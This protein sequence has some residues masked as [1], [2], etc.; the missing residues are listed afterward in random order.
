MKNTSILLRG[1]ALLALSGPALAQGGMIPL[2]DC[3]LQ[4]RPWIAEVTTF[5]C[6]VDCVANQV[7]LEFDLAAKS[8][9][10][11]IPRFSL[12]GCT[13]AVCPFGA[14]TF[15]YVSGANVLLGAGLWEV[16]GGG[17]TSSS[18][19]VQADF[20]A[21]ELVSVI[22][23]NDITQ[24][25]WKALPTGVFN[26]TTLFWETTWDTN[27]FDDP[28]GYILRVDLIDSIT[29]P[30]EAYT[31]A[32]DLGSCGFHTYG[33][34][35]G[36]ANTLTLDGSAGDCPGSTASFTTKTTTA[37]V[38]FTSISLNGALAPFLGGTLFVD[39]AQEVLVGSAP[40]LGGSSQ[41]LVPVPPNPGLV[42]L[43]VFS[44]SLAFEPAG[45]VFSNGLRLDFCPLGC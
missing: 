13:S 6:G 10:P 33:Q 14:E 41:L 12:P 34:G 20:Y 32:A 35:I 36:G 37:P 22:A 19:I 24:L 1:A 40:V 18:S 26:P 29:G 31:I 45:L 30:M 28:A 17:W 11:F 4:C 9:E 7:E 15:Q 23:E 21:V 16:P 5:D 2:P 44:Q 42:G 43:S 27:D 38:V 8:G 3:L 39:V 25:P